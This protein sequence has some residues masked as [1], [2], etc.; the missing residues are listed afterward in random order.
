[1][2]Q[3]ASSFHPDWFCI[4]FLLKNTQSNDRERS[5]QCGSSEVSSCTTNALVY[6]SSQP[7][8]NR[9]GQTNAK[10]NH[11]GEAMRAKA[12]AHAAS[13]MPTIEAI[14]AAGITGLKPIARELIRRGVPTFRGGR[15]D[16]TRVRVL[17]GRARS[18]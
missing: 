14:R 11:G 2:P 13:V 18:F 17:I 9:M 4:Q 8:V 1:M 6:R 10:V 7:I 16:A 3:R 15:W 12:D 5:G